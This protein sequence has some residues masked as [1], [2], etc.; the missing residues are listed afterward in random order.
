[1]ARVF[2]LG[3]ACGR[4]KRLVQTA[5]STA[6]FSRFCKLFLRA[7]AIPLLAGSL[8]C[9]IPAAAQL[10]SDGNLFPTLA[11]D[12]LLGASPI[13]A[14]LARALAVG[15]F[16][17][18]GN[19]DLTTGIAGKNVEAGGSPVVGESG[20]VMVLNGAMSLGLT[21]FDGLMHAIPGQDLNGLVDAGVFRAL[22]GTTNGVT[23]QLSRLFGHEPPLP[24]AQPWRPPGLR[25]HP[26]P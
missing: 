14:T 24:G 15:D 2:V 22:Y 16:D 23:N 17:G 19:D 13:D 4:Q 26:P 3:R 12:G 18:D 5:I 21:N 6:S 9:A 8:F 20:A 1:M 7:T 25:P 11:R 10:G